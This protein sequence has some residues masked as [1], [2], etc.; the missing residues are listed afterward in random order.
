MAFIK[1]KAKVV[2]QHTEYEDI[3]TPD[4][5]IKIALHGGIETEPLD[6]PELVKLLGIIMKFEPM[7][8]DDS[9]SLRKDKKTGIWHM[10]VN[11]LHHPHRQ[12]FTIA[13]EIG[14]HVKHGA[15]ADEFIDTTF[16]RNDE[17]NKQEAEANAFAAELLMPTNKFN[18][19]I[20]AGNTQVEDISKHFLV[21]SM[22]VR[23][24]AKQLGYQGHN[25]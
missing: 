20:N 21:S 8:G 24:R 13:H 11:S 9:G 25:L 6:I 7:K 23:I 1:R 12:R 19:F 5:V 17:S 15:F 18:A 4:D 2:H 14:H 22:A 3:N 10:V 16:F